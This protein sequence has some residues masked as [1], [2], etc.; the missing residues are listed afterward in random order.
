MLKCLVQIRLKVVPVSRKSLL[1]GVSVVRVEKSRQELQ[2]SE[3]KKYIYTY[4]C[5]HICMLYMYIYV[6]IYTYIHKY[7][8]INIL[9]AQRPFE[10]RE[11]RECGKVIDAK[12]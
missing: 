9:V 1:G 6:Y 7:I 2:D 4:I 11:W 10:Q 8:C 12:S 3:E 5:I